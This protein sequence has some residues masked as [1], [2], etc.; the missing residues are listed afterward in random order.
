[1]WK[2]LIYYERIFQVGC[3]ITELK[4]YLL[5]LKKNFLESEQILT[6]FETRIQ[7]LSFFHNLMLVLREAIKS[8]QNIFVTSLIYYFQNYFVYIFF[9]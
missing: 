2:F 6:F 4:N 7:K 8:N 9:K 3:T 1:M 5:F